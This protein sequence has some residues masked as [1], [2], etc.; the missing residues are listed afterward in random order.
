MFDRLFS[1][2]G[3]FNSSCPCNYIDRQHCHIRVIIF[4][5]DIVPNFQII[6]ACHFQGCNC[7]DL[8]TLLWSVVLQVSGGQQRQKEGEWLVASRQ[9]SY[10]SQ[11][12]QIIFVEK[13]FHVEKFWEI[14]R[15]F[16]RFCHNLRAFMWKKIGPKKYICGEKMTNM[17]SGIGLYWAALGCTGL[18]RCCS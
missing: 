3:L 11:I 9:T 12:S 17:R 8:V 5:S 1:A 6:K 18:S 7:V 16:G 2:G 4:P 13:K 14:L 15:N 10:L